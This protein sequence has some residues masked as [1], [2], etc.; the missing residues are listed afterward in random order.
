M[1]KLSK[2][3]RASLPAST[4]ALPGRRFPIPDAAHARAAEMSTKNLSPSQKATV[5]S[6]ARQVLGVGMTEHAKAVKKIIK[7]NPGY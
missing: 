3:A 1:A 4:F 6:K 2:G 7:N 5:D